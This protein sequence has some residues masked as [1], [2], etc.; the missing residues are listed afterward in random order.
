ME[1][2]ICE[3]APTFDGWAY[4]SSTLYEAFT[5]DAIV[6]DD[7]REIMPAREYPTRIEHHYSREFLGKS[8]G[9]TFPLPCHGRIRLDYSIT[10]RT[11]KQCGNEWHRIVLSSKNEHRT[12][13]VYASLNQISQGVR[14]V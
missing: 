11:C 6:S 4:D 12:A 10:C 14:E 1:R 5:A 13:I 9:D 8:E 7:G 3:N 2:V